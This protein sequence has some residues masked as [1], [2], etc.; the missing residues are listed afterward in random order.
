M[1]TQLLKQTCDYIIRHTDNNN[2]QEASNGWK[3]LMAM[4]RMILNN[5]SRIRAGRRQ[6]GDASHAKAVRTRIQQVYAGQFALLLY[7]DETTSK[8]PRPNTRQSKQHQ[9]Q[10]EQQQRDKH[11]IKAIMQHLH[12][13]EL[14]QALKVL[15]G[16]PELATAEQIQAEL[17]EL[18]KQDPQSPSLPEPATTAIDPADIEAITTNIERTLARTPKH[19]GPGPAGERYEHYGVVSANPPPHS[20]RSHAS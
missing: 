7:P 11:D 20:R 17:P 6:Q 9:Q 13:N 12:D 1:Y 10:D 19:R 5:T 14:A 16:P 3:L 15:H 2:L 4:P 8:R 18:I